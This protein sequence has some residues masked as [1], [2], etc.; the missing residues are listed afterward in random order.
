MKSHQVN[1]KNNNYNNNNNS[2]KERDRKVWIHIFIHGPCSWC[3][4]V[5]HV[6]CHI[7]N[8]TAWTF[9]MAAKMNTFFDVSALI[10]MKEHTHMHIDT[11][12]CMCI[13]YI[14]IYILISKR[15][16]PKKKKLRQFSF[17]L[18]LYLFSLLCNDLG[19]HEMKMVDDHLDVYMHG[20]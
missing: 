11:H 5:V 15:T 13:V 4:L 17:R 14:Y 10:S 6:V 2:S 7:L 19:A 8:W 1:S 9:N 3:A 18:I 12:L 16:K 20:F